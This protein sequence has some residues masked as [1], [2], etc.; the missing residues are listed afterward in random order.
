VTDP[1]D[2][3]SRLRGRE[4]QGSAANADSADDPLSDVNEEALV[5]LAGHWKQAGYSVDEALRWYCWCFEFAERVLLPCWFFYGLY[6]SVLL[7]RAREG[8]YQSMAD[9]LSLDGSMV[10]DPKVAEHWHWIRHYGSAELR[11][12]M[13][14]ALAQSPGQ[15]VK[16]GRVKAAAGAVIQLASELLGEPLNTEQIRELFDQHAGE[17]AGRIDTDLP[18]SKEAWY[19]AVDRQRE[20][21]LA[22]LGLSASEWDSLIRLHS[23]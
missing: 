14:K 1:A 2:T 16:A 15:D 17:G 18:D 12:Q 8:D 4:S 7:R 23:K 21:I 11:D 10:T 6:P 9:L 5:W 19:R 13:T 20:G 3:L 22:G